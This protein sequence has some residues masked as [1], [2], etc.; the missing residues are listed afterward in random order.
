MNDAKPWTIKS[1][2]EVASRRAT[3]CARRNDQTA[4]EWLTEAIN[5]YADRQANTAVIP[6]VGPGL[7]APLPAFSG[8]APAPVDLHGLADALRATAEAATASG[9]PLPA[10]LVREASALLREQIRTA[11]GLPARRTGQPG[12]KTIQI[13]GPTDARLGDAS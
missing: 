6:P 10:G 3:E 2:P 9:K 8:S 11:R 7:P 12:G 13:E 5:A 1:M 4:A